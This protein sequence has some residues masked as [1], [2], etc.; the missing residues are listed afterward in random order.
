MASFQA[1]GL[2]EFKKLNDTISILRDKAISYNEGV[3]RSV[4][5]TTTSALQ[6]SAKEQVEAKI[7]DIV[8]EIKKLT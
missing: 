4:Q 8:Q 5:Q 2:K 6:V 1:I 7:K 3:A